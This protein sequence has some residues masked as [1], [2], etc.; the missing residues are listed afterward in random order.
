MSIL[1]FLLFEMGLIVISTIF[2][3]I[4]TSPKTSVYA[5]YHEI[6][7]LI[8]T[9]KSYLVNTMSSFMGNLSE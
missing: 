1:L 2:I 8:M 9:L 3:C 6:L 4:I 7:W 5:N